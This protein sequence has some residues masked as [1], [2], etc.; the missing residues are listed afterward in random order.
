MRFSESWLREWINPPVTTAELAHRLTMIGLEVDAIEPAAPDFSGVVVA[1]VCAVEPHPAADKLRVTR[2]RTGQTEFQV[3]CGAP[4]VA[5]GMRVPF[6]TVGAALPGGLTIR[7]ASLRG[8][9]SLGMLCSATELGLPATND[10][11]WALPSDAPIG[12]DLRAWLQL[13]DAVIELGITP[14]RGDALSI[15]G[16]ARDCSA[17]F[18]QPLLDQDR[19]LA[20]PAVTGSV[21]PAAQIAAPQDCPVYRLQVIEQ[22]P[23]NRSTPLWLAERLRRAGVKV[24][25]PIVDICNY[26]MLELGQPLHAFDADRLTGALT[27]RRARAGEQFLALNQQ[28]LTLTDECLIIADEHAPVALAG[29]IGGADSAVQAGT[30]RIVLESAYFTPEALAGRARQ[31]GIATD[32]A[33]RFERGVDP[34]LSE[35]ALNR[36]VA[37]IVSICGGVASPPIA[38][39]G[40]RIA[41]E[42]CPIVLDMDWASAR[43]GL[44][45]PVDQAMQFLERLGCRME[46]IGAQRLTVFPPSHRFDLRIAEDLLEELARLIGF[47]AFDAP[48]APSATVLTVPAETRNRKTM[49]AD[50]LVDLGYFEAITYSFIDPAVA[51]LFAATPGIALANPISSEMA[52]MRQ[53]LWPGLLMALRFNQNR[54][55]NRVRLFEIGRSFHG[56][57]DGREEIDRIAG[58][59]TGSRLP[60]QWAVPSVSVDFFDLKGDVQA[61]LSR[62]GFDAQSEDETTRVRFVAAPH[63]ALHPGQSAAIYLGGRPVGWLGA[64]H[65]LVQQAMDLTGSVYVFELSLAAVRDRRLPV[66][67]PRSRFPQVRR[68]L[69][70]LKPVSISADE[71]LAII[72]ADQAEYLREVAIFDRFIGAGIPEGFESVAVKL[73]LQAFERTLTD[74]EII[75]IISDIRTKLAQHQIEL[76]S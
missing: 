66:N 42:P 75:A 35:R 44:V 4:N 12:A 65:P 69:A 36:A 31:F 20:P 72:A 60:E 24:I 62:L 27:V 41:F 18:D 15:L 68:D 13:D 25:E 39:P 63:Q 14:N 21:V 47:D 30:Q 64:L 26:V 45:I 49:V 10:G 37:L 71:L 73:V 32:A 59:I 46:R 2:V 40:G 9:E 74:E 57:L 16:L 58:V 6:A 56:S 38:A 70:L 76:R 61:L 55:Q 23:T 48:L 1:E 19:L 33:F 17:L 53:S 52:V 11:L 28:R 29:V 3:V 54:Q 67:R 22:I 7:A 8:V 51:G 43:L 5:V 34:L 50:V